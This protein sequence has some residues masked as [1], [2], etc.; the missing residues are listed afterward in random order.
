MKKQRIGYL[1]ALALIVMG[2]SAFTV[3]AARVEDVSTTATPIVTETPEPTHNG[4]ETPAAESTA[5]VAT[6]IPTTPMKPNIAVIS[7]ENAD[8][9]SEESILG[10][11][12]FTEISVSPDHQYVAYSSSI[13]IRVLAADTLTEL[14]FIESSTPA[15]TLDFS[16][17][18]AYLVA[19][20][21]NGHLRVYPTADLT[22]NA[23]PVFDLKASALPVL[24]VQFAPS[25][26]TFV[27]A[28]QDRNV[29]TWDV[30]TGKKMHTFTGF[31][32]DLTDVAYSAD[33][34]YIAVSSSDGSI[35][36]WNSTSGYLWKEYA[37]EQVYGYK[38]LYP[39]ALQFDAQTGKLFSGWSDGTLLLWQ[40]QFG[41]D[42]PLTVSLGTKE[43]TEL[44]QPG[45]QTL[46]SLDGNGKALV[47]NTADTDSKIGVAKTEEIDLGKTTRDIAMGAT[48]N[49]WYVGSS[50]AEIAKYDQTEKKVTLTYNR[51]KT[52]SQPV[53]AVAGWQDDI[54]ITGNGAGLIQ[55]WELNSRAVSPL[56]FTTGQ[57]AITGLARSGNG[58]W[59]AVASAAQVD[60]YD[61]SVI[62]A[63]YK[64]S[65]PADQIRPAAQI[66]TGGNVAL[67]SL[68]ADGNLLA[69]VNE[70]TAAVQMW[71]TADGKKLGE[72]NANDNQA[73]VELAF[74]DS[75][76][77]LAVGTARHLVYF[78]N[79]LE[80][81]SFSE[82]SKK[83]DA[84][85]DAG[86]NL[87]SLTWA[88]QVHL[89]AAAGQNKQVTV[90]NI[91]NMNKVKLA[92]YLTGAKA[93]LNS[94]AFSPDGTLLAAAGEDGIIRIYITEKGKLLASLEGHIGGI[95]QL[96]FS[97]AGDRIISLGQDGTIRLWSVL[98]Q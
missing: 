79:N 70:G 62:Q 86:T 76:D 78:W 42:K 15:N 60:V 83:Y 54:L 71:G 23:E 69:I 1:L 32:G 5:A 45:K 6:I 49:T 74:S 94:T 29:I 66:E 80:T 88:E 24:Q 75:S 73:I 12:S 55:V 16:P 53:F 47:W 77:N 92:Y 13:G 85:F 63:V 36:V 51:P 91:E 56:E 4:T 68:S 89:F 2:S 65:T 37:A 43:I 84:V 44:L 95:H 40:W 10:D 17:D 22:G 21:E 25:G 50:P 97:A 61:L 18:S 19:G 48:A 27:S 26:T 41:D 31:N 7:Q 52:G 67:L 30:A 90:E 38:A 34:R 8:N 28:S 20:F 59:L 72:L 46:I 96:L 82:A 93:S 64:G 57:D 81:S 33:G 87:T 98:A 14:A 58:Q 39:T 9:L 3:Q 35:R 11:G